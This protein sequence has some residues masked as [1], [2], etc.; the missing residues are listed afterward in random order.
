MATIQQQ[1]YFAEH[2]LPSIGANADQLP[3][4]D[5]TGFLAMAGRLYGNELM[6]VGR[7]VNGW[8]EGV[9]P[10]ELSSPSSVTAYAEKVFKSVV[11]DESC[12][13]AW[14]TD[15][16]ANPDS[17]YNTKKSAFWRAIRAVVAESGVANTD[18]ATWPSHLVWSNLYKIA[19]AEGGNPSNAL[20][21]VQLA[22]CISLFQQELNDYRPRRLLFLT[23]LDWAE[24]YLQHV[25][26]TFT[27]TPA[28]GYVEA[29]ADIR[30]ESGHATKV[31]VA[32]HPQG[33][34]GSVWVQEVM[35]AFQG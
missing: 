17:E 2:L 25:A 31:V 30:H 4:Q 3:E 12:P 35:N 18:D 1:N 27:P 10:S 16:W 28:G 14:V 20:C 5:V 22:G 34:S 9:T 11:G 13:M 6:V 29:L 19:P 23:G 33:K 21:Q 26:P 7:A 32:A 24:P 15:C 8:T